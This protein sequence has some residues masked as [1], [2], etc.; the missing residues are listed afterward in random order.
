MSGTWALHI[1]IDIPTH[2]QR[3]WGPQFLWPLL[4]VAVDGL[5]WAEAAASVV[6]CIFRTR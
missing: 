2:S 6:A 1:L 5:S 3:R 4:G